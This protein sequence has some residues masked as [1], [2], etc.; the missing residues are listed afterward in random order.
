MI[1]KNTVPLCNPLGTAP[2]MAG[3]LN[4][5]WVF[6]LPGVPWEMQRMLED[7]LLSRLKTQENII[8]HRIVH[9]FGRGESDIGE[10]ISDLMQRDADPIVGTTVAAGMVSIRVLSS[11]KTEA[12]AQKKA[13]RV[14]DEIHH[15]LGI[16]V[17]GEEEDTMADVVGRLLRQRGQTLAV[18]ESCTG[19]LIG[20]MLTDASG[21]SDYFRGGVL[22]YANDLKRD[23]LGVNESMLI[24]HGAVSEPVAQAMAEGVRLRANADYALSV[25]GIAGPTGGTQEKPVGLVYLALASEEG[26][27]VFRHLLPGTR[28]IVRL[29]VA[30]TAMNHLRLLLLAR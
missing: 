12:L 13:Q 28:E 18:A 14:I 22:A 17:V 5:A 16:T 9:T 27:Q 8:L 2:G 1:P 20:K 10:S 21:S 7:H 19:G 15:R 25:T 29:R 3:F 6:V 23:L 24:E 4:E 30:L 11:D 26:T